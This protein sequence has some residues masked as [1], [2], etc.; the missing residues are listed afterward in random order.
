MAL[1][2]L[3]DV[4]PERVQ[5]L[6][7]RRIP[8]GKLVTIDGDPGLGK[9]TL[10]VDV[11]ATITI[12][13]TW[14]DGSICEYPGA[15]LLMSAEDGLA[16]TV[17]PRFDAAGADVTKVHAVQGVPIDDEGTLRPPTIADIAALEQAITDTGARAV[18]IDVLMAY[19]PT[20][21]DS[22]KDQD[23][24]STLSRLAAL[25]DRTNCT[26]LLIRHLTKA[27][28]RDPIYRGG[29][30][31]GIVGAARAGLL[32]AS[33]PDEPEN[34]V[35]ASVK[36]NLAPLPESLTYQLVDA[37]EHGCARVRWGG[38]TSHTAHT[39]LSETNN[40]EPGNPAKAFI[41]D[42]LRTHGGEA[43]AADVLKAG[44][45]AGF[46]DNELKHA[47]QR[48]SK[49]KISSRKA[50]MNDGWVWATDPDESAQPHAGAEGAG[51]PCA[52]PSAPSEGETAPSGAPPG[53]PTVSTPGLTER[54][55]DALSKAR[56]GHRRNPCP[57]CGHYL[58]A[59]GH[60]SD[61]CTA[62]QGGDR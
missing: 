6:W 15:V 16:D 43:S 11:G 56:N 10:A 57:G 35:L 39:L 42:Y 31:I 20:G 46:S 36:S 49:P 28:G 4:Q 27:A 19:L 38:T 52:A 41:I 54:V 61:N 9:S 26:L 51:N 45:A 50:S 33:D 25:A 34:R 17:R 47:R 40:D 18:V 53:A 22:H 13:G 59:R 8:L 3:A 2:R 23:I 5:W 1:T 32:V 30:S 60:H 44:R 14:P 21:T 62:Q 7:P 12:G 48:A 24:R 58:V 55:A 29:G 37:P